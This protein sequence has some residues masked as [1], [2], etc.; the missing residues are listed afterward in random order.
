MTS[1]KIFV[2]SDVVISSLISKNGAAYILLF[3]TKNLEALISNFSK[4][5]LYM[6]AKNLKIKRE[7]LKKLI[8]ERLKILKLKKN[9]AEIKKEFKDYVT[10]SN[11]C[12][13]LAGAVYTKVNFLVSYN[14]KHFKIEKIKNSFKIITLTPGKFLQYLRSL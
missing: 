9:L 6:V 3:K 5:E 14:L 11:D 12:H 4:K 13:I 7:K 2:D 1:T 8:K 10:D